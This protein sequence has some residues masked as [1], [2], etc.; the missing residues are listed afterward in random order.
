MTIGVATLHFSG[1]PRKR[2]ERLGANVMPGGLKI[3][4]YLW[5]G[6]TFDFSGNLLLGRRVLSFA[7]LSMADLSA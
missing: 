1:Q 2:T 7:T 6:S 5:P 3:Q 4:L